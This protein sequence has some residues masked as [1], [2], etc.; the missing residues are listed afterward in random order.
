MM[1]ALIMTARDNAARDAG[2]TLGD[3][4]Y[5]KRQSYVEE[6]EWVALVR[7]SA[8]GDHGALHAL[9]DRASK[10]VFTLAMRITRDRPTAKR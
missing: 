2:G 7:A 1:D 8:G 5:D 10:I 9:Y 6:S 4:L 3:L